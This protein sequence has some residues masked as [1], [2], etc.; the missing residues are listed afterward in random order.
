MMIIESIASFILFINDNK[1]IGHNIIDNIIGKAKHV[2]GTQA[3]AST[4]ALSASIHRPAHHHGPSSSDRPIQSTSLYPI[5]STILRSTLEISSL[6]S[7][8]ASPTAPKIVLE[9]IRRAS[10]FCSLSCRAMPSIRSERQRAQRKY[11]QATQTREAGGRKGSP[12]GESVKA[13]AGPL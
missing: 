5:Q 10:Q 8:S 6:L 1:L 11:Q 12:L 13:G 7:S 9:Q 2:F 3:T 4:R